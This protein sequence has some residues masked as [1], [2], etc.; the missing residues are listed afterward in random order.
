M[1]MLKPNLL[2]K[3]YTITLMHRLSWFTASQDS[4]PNMQCKNIKCTQKKSNLAAC[5]MSHPAVCTCLDICWIT[6]HNSG[7]SVSV[8]LEIFI[9]L[10]SHAKTGG[11]YHKRQWQLPGYFVAFNFLRAIRRYNYDRPG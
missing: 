11:N 9:D 6:S 7:C 4:I 3:C 10:R 1:V 2:K 8:C 5:S